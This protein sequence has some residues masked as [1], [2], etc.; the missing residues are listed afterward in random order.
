MEGVR[1]IYLVTLAAA[2]APLAAGVILFGWRSL[3]VAAI[4]V[5]SCVLIEKAYYR[6]T[7]TPALLGRS[8][9]AMTGVLLALTLPAFVPWYV[10]IIAA[11]FAIV[12]GKAIFGGVGH[13]LWQPALLGRLA[14]AV[15]LPATMNPTSWPL[16]AQNR[17]MVGDITRAQQVDD[18]RQWRGRPA[19]A[20]A[21]AFLLTRPSETLAALTAG[22]TAEYRALAYPDD[23]SGAGGQLLMRLPPINEM[24]YGATPGGIGETCAIVIVIA[25]L[26]L[27]YRNYVKWQLPLAFILTAW[28]VAAVAPIQ[29]TGPADSI[30]TVWWPLLAEGGDVGFTYVNY[31]LLSGEL[32]LAAFFMA[33]EMTSRPV[34]SGGQVIFGIGCGIIAMLL[35][36]YVHV[37]IPSYM[38][39]L[40]MNTL[41]PAI[42]AIWRPRVL[43]QRR[44]SYLKSRLRWR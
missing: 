36:L 20:G 22:E 27:I 28:A 6:S 17:L 32:L 44:I 16:L 30:R 2:C 8:H 35:K 18:Y 7:R 21:D 42:D 5:A 38:A 10:P 26:Y 9:A 31:Q 37:P 43:G 11:V 4:S 33:P 39:V 3:L 23:D 13:F 12:V 41:T 1:T 14:V 19:P 25:G 40:A 15:L 29:L 24:L 34:T